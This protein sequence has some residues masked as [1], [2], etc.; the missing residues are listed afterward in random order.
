[1]LFRSL[2]KIV[3]DNVLITG[4]A[5]RLAN[6]FLGSGIANA[7][8]SGCLAGCISTDFIKKKINNLELYQ[9]ILRSK[10][11]RLTKVYHK[12]NKRFS[13]KNFINAYARTFSILSFG[14]KLFPNFF[15]K[16]IKNAL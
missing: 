5:A 15:H 11:N 3:K 6:S 1:M 9:E 8:F 12:R 7:I 2:N 13:D 4:D 16:K 10:I 14:N